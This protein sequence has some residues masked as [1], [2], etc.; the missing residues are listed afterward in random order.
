MTNRTLKLRGMVCFVLVLLGSSFHRLLAG[1]IDSSLKL[2]NTRITMPWSEVQ[3][4]AGKKRDTIYLPEETPIP[5]SLIYHN[6]DLQIRLTDSIANCRLEAHYSVL[7]TKPWSTRIFLPHETDYAF[8]S[9]ISSVGDFLQ[10]TDSGYV[11]LA[12]KKKSGEKRILRCS[13]QRA[14]R[15][16]E[17]LHQLNLRIPSVAQ[18]KIEIQTPTN[19]S[20][21]KVRNAILLH[22]KRHKSSIW[23]TFS[24]PQNSQVLELTYIPP[25]PRIKKDSLAAHIEDLSDT[26][27]KPKIT[28]NQETIIFV[29]ENNAFL[30]TTLHLEVLQAPIHEFTIRLSPD[31]SLLRVAGNGIRQWQYLD[32]NYLHIALTF[33]LLGTY[34]LSMVGEMKTDSII[35]VPGFTVPEAHRQKGQYAI[36]VE[37]NGETRVLSRENCSPMPRENFNRSISAV[38][39]QNLVQYKKNSQ[40]I[41]LAATI[42][43]HPFSAHYLI[44]RY[45]LVPVANAIADSGVIITA[46]TKDWKAVTRATYWVNQRNKQFLS[47]TLPDTCDLWSVSLHGKELAPFIGDD[48]V[49]KVSL[50][51][52]VSQT[53]RLNSLVVQFTFFQK[54]TQESKTKNLKMTAPVPDIPVNSLSWSIFYP[55]SWYAFKTS[56]DFT[57]TRS[58]L[59]GKKRLQL[60]EQEQTRQY[61]RILKSN[62]TRQKSGL[63]MQLPIQ[64]DDLKHRYGKRILV[65]HE[66]PM[67]VLGFTSQ[68]M[69]TIIRVLIILV[70]ISFLVWLGLRLWPRIKRIKN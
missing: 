3:K 35:R 17:G 31:F 33:D 20:E 26:T 21:V 50:Q 49:F 54:L 1:E 29:A 48:G 55:R 5:S 7:S 52:Y 4:L 60:T 15:Q 13:W 63:A 24:L 14:T 27:K 11:L 6:V 70:G 42:T 41:L 22:K 69:V 51:R 36:A 66:K 19:F 39:R 44:R 18:G 47:F 34:T 25:P 12:R 57:F 65:V 32:S 30:L 56:G 67:L 37:G 40:D 10:A 53:M 68:K 2:P 43:K 45:A 9:I 58:T 46:L 38:M 61:K 8:T 23:Y 62:E 59:V 28:N 64:V 16:R